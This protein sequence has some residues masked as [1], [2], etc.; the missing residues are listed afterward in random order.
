MP[1]NEGVAY[2]LVVKTAALSKTFKM[3]TCKGPNVL[4][5]FPFIVKVQLIV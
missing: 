3:L 4:A 5:P 1:Q 2:T